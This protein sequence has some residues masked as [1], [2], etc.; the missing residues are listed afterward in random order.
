MHLKNRLSK[1][2]LNEAIRLSELHFIIKHYLLTNKSLTP[3][4][5]LQGSESTQWR[6]VAEDKVLKPHLSG[7]QIRSEHFQLNTLHGQ[8]LALR[9]TK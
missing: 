3:T 7:K 6:S 4:P 2:D 9:G 1:K 5:V 8:S